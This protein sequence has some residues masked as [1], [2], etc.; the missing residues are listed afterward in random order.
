M[1]PRRITRGLGALLVAAALAVG[2]ATGAAAQQPRAGAAAASA[3]GQKVIFDT[4]FG[5][6]NDDSQALYLLLQAKAD[7][8]GVTT[9]SGNTWAAEGAAYALRQLELVHRQDIPVYQG[10][11]DPLRGSRQGRLDRDAKRFGKVDYVG[12]WG[13]KRPASYR[14]LA[15]AP[16]RGYAATPKARGSAVDFI[17]NTVKR[18][19][20]QVTLFVLGPATNVAKA[21]RTHPEIAPLVKQVIYMG[22]AYDVPGNS[23]PAAE[24]NVWFDPEASRIALNAPFPKQT[25][26]PLDVTDTVLMRKAQYDRVAAGPDTPITREFRDLMGPEFAKDPSYETYIYD[27]LTSAVLLDPGLVTRASDRG[28]QVDTHYGLDYGRTLGYAPDLA[29][30]GTRRARIVERIDVPAFFDLY[31]KEMTKPV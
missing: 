22:G 12:A 15:Q 6:L 14:H 13:R 9:V 31:V 24:F 30:Q 1:R 27:S 18:N 5:Q 17:V 20:H 2:G 4:D 11:S 21:V 19:P 10:A 7:V 16:Y 25:I 28:V 26:V 29:P 8:L 23:G 3:A